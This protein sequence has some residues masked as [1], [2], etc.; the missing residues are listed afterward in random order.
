MLNVFLFVH[1]T[2]SFMRN[3][4]KIQEKTCELKHIGYFEI[5]LKLSRMN[6]LNDLG[7]LIK[8]LIAGHFLLLRYF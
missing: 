3:D 1:F 5:I 7:N 4:I 6:E 2:I 8:M